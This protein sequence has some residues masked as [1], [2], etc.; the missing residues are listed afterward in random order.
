[1]SNV[2]Y[3][4]TT[5]GGLKLAEHVNTALGKIDEAGTIK[6]LA[7]NSTKDGALKEMLEIG[8]ATK[9]VE[10]SVGS[11]TGNVSVGD[12]LTG[13]TSGAEGVLVWQNDVGSVAHMIVQKVSGTFQ[14]GET[15]TGNGN[16]N[17]MTITAGTLVTAPGGGDG[18]YP[19]EVLF[20]AE[21]GSGPAVYDAIV[22]AMDGMS[23]LRSSYSVLFQGG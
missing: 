12:T 1:M 18:K 6:S 3:D 16:G 20:G 8:Y 23:A 22:A 2:Q 9:V 21:A 4:S 17:T 19:G 15:V 11:Q 13:G 5:V 10:F 14:E 7:D